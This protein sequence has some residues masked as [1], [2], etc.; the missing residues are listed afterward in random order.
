MS[1][2]LADA[3]PSLRDQI[4]S[5]V[6][7]HSSSPDIESVVNGAKEEQARDIRTRGAA[8]PQP[9]RHQREATSVDN[10]RSTIR[11][12][13]NDAR[14]KAARGPQSAP[15]QTAP[16]SA[17]PAGPPAS[18]DKPAQA[19]WHTL[20][21]EVRM[22]TLRGEAAYKE[23]IDN[24][25][26]LRDYRTISESLAPLR[27]VFEQHGIKSPSQAVSR[28]LQWEA[29]FRNPETRKHAFH[30]L[31]QEYGM[32]PPWEGMPAQQQAQSYSP[33]YAASAE[34]TIREYS[35]RPNFARV[36]AIMGGLI[37]AEPARYVAADDSVNVELAFQDACRVK[38]IGPAPAQPQRRASPV[39]DSA[40]R[41]TGATVRETLMAAARGR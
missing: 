1:T 33:E 25:P 19:L 16:G 31:A 12:A 14:V 29:S 9:D 40:R 5:A 3:G 21:Q 4:E 18:W 24:H 37:M 6:A 13:V 20:P 23:A 2:E 10:R 7:S 36:S 32:P 34:R 8:G 11:D 30:Q 38:G 28:L 22:A 35:S 41:G 15:A 17:I 39:P 26:D 27:G